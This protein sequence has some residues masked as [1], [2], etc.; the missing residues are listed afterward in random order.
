MNTLVAHDS[1]ARAVLFFA[2]P[3]AEESRI[4]RVE[5]AEAIFALAR[6]RVLAAVDAL[7][8]VALV[9]VGDLG[10]DARLPVGT[11]VMEQ[12]GRGFGSKLSNAFTDVRALGY[13][14]VVA[15]GLD[16]PGLEHADLEAAFQALESHDAVLGPARDGGAYVIG[17]RVEP[18]A[19]FAGVRWRSRHTASD[20][21]R[22]GLICLETEHADID[23][24]HALGALWREADAELRALLR[25]LITRPFVAIPLALPLPRQVTRGLDAP[26]GPP[27]RTASFA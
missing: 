3:P 27:L 13:S 1:P 17:A 22:H 20:L 6:D 11:R 14:T 16:T 5:K 7:D 19:L 15:V 2:R 4:K 9:V 18:S 26:R 21:I 24:R 25:Q 8:D 10:S 23:G 12:R